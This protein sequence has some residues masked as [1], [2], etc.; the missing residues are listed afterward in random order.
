MGGES[1]GAAAM[2]T[3]SFGLGWAGWRT[4]HSAVR[5]GGRVCVWFEARRALGGAERWTRRAESPGRS[6]ARREGSGGPFHR[7]RHGHRQIRIANAHLAHSSRPTLRP[8]P[9][10]PCPCPPL[11][12][13]ARQPVV[14]SLSPAGPGP[15][16]AC[17]R[18]ALA[19]LE[20]P[21]PPHQKPGASLRLR[22]DH[23]APRRTEPLPHP[24]WPVLQAPPRK[25]ALQLLAASHVAPNHRQTPGPDVTRF[26]RC[27]SC[28]LWLWSCREPSRV[29][30]VLGALRRE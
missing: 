24:R 29:G 28:T 22:L 17:L 2:A 16:R 4:G 20:T 12:A 14:P 18:P 5:K 11:P 30:V 1:V 13:L 3:A 23:R 19:P 21:P 26:R 15:A 25:K 8:A 7:N 6:G 9:P 10:Q 27:C